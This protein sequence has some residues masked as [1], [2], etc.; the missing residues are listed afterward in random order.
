MSSALP[1]ASISREQNPLNIVLNVCYELHTTPSSS[2]LSPFSAPSASRSL[3]VLPS[4]FRT[5]QRHC[6]AEPDGLDN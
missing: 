5:P 3:S 1:S 6:A 2:T 4:A